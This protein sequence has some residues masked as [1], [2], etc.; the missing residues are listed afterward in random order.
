MSDSNE[1]TTPPKLAHPLAWPL[2]IVINF[3]SIIGMTVVLPVLP[4][5]V[6]E[7]VPQASLALWVGALESVYSV[8]AFLAAPLLGALSDRYGRKPILVFSVLGSAVGYALFG[9]GGALWVLLA[10][11][12]ID[13][14]TAGDMPVLFAYIADITPAG[15][16]ARRFGLLGALG[17]IG[18]MAGPALGAALAR[19]S[20]SA[21][22]FATAGIAVLVGVLSLVVLPESLAPEKRTSALK[23]A[24][25]HPFKVIRDAFARPEL[26][27]LLLGFTLV[28]LPFSFFAN[29]F[30]VVALD[31][32]GWGPT[33]VGTLLT[34]IGVVDILVQG[35]LLRVLLPRIGER[36]VAVAGVV[37]Q[38]IGCLGIAVA[39]SLL[40]VPWLMASAS[41]IFA[42]GQGG[43]TAALDGLMSSAVGPDEQGWLGGGLSSLGSAVQMTGPLLAGWLYMAFNHAAPY[44]LGAVLIAASAITLGRA[45]RHRPATSTA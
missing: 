31:S 35:V 21:P 37:A 17:G 11:R 10:S 33:Q 43:Q 18:M 36:G 13:G 2:I 4:F 41:L 24:E 1:S 16:R 45:L 30:S 22:L 12:V 26:R 19:V 44:W 39:A 32:V 6:R 5:V 20:L 14:L 25:L 34:G 9:V 38:L 28:S 7:Y 8:C 40:R 15:E 27:W 23:V 42:A 29:N 3:L